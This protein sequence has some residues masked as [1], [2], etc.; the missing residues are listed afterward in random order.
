MF[1]LCTVKRVK[2][3]LLCGFIYASKLKDLTDLDDF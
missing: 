3:M 1:R 2:S